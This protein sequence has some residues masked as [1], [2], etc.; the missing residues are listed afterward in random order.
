[1]KAPF[2]TP[3][4]KAMPPFQPVPFEKSVQTKELLECF[5]GIA[6]R[7]MIVTTPPTVT[8]KRPNCCKCGRNLLRKIVT[9]IQIQVMQTRPTKTFQG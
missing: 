7:T 6:A 1:M 9:A 5:L 2:K 4:R 3:V 8:M